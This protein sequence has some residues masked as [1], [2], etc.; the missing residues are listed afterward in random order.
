[1]G[2]RIEALYESERLT[3]QSRP[4]T[5][6]LV[7]GPVEAH[8]GEERRRTKNGEK[9]EEGKRDP[10]SATITTEND[11]F[12][13]HPPIFTERTTLLFF[14]ETRRG[15]SCKPVLSRGFYSKPW[16]LRAARFDPLYRSAT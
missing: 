16:S 7:T 10:T 6:A 3:R 4:Y 13:N 9:K 2:R 1:M 14:H 11:P 8:Y 15:T 5:V 12:R